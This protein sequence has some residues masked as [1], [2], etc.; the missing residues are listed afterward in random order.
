[1]DS[2]STVITAIALF[3]AGFVC[4][5]SFMEAWLKFKAKGV[6]LSVGLSIGKKIFKALNRVEWL[7]LAILIVT[8]FYHFEFGTNY[9]ITLLSLL[10][11][12][13]LIQ[14]FYLLPQLN[15]RADLIM[16]GQKVDRSF[17]HLQYISVDF[18]KLCILVFTGFWSY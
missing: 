17:I 7:L 5:I 14:T 4:A 9:R 12:I 2:E 16:E 8:W 18:I 11:I 6:T 15:K 10:F 1:M 13:L 3:W